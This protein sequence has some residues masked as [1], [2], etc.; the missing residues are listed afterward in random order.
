METLLYSAAEPETLVAH[1][2]GSYALPVKSSG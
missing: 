2:T 1:V